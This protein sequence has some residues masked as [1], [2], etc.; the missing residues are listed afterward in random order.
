VEHCQARTERAQ[1][2]HILFALCARMDR[3]AAITATAHKLARIIYHLLTTG[4]CY[5]ETLFA[6][7]QERA[8]Q[9]RERRMRR[10]AAMLGYQLVPQVPV[11]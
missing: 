11:T 9:R 1:R 10:D 4:E 5:D 7:E 6:Q 3:A 8:R 2:N